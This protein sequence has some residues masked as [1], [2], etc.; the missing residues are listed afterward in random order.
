MQLSVLFLDPGLVIK[1]GFK[2]DPALQKTSL[3]IVH[4]PAGFL[5]IPN[6]DNIKKQDFNFRICFLCYPG[7]VIPV[8]P[9]VRLMGTLQTSIGFNTGI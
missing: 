2:S 1:Y 6:L 3:D 8:K 7:L 4:T 9:D 5:L